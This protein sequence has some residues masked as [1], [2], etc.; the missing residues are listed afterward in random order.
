[1][2]HGF[3]TRFNKDIV[4]GG[5]QSQLLLLLSPQDDYP[6][7]RIPT[8]LS[9]S[10]WATPPASHN[11]SSDS[12]FANYTLSLAECKEAFSYANLN[13]TAFGEELTQGG[14]M[15]GCCLAYETFTNNTYDPASPPWLNPVPEQNRPDCGNDYTAGDKKVNDSNVETS[16]WAVTAFYRARRMLEEEDK[17][18]GITTE[19]STETV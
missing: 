15:S 18:G 3:R 8:W 10:T 5:R 17:V 11:C 2:E 19:N 4:K 12:L 13:Y 7:R 1:M 6:E 9:V 14:S 16:F